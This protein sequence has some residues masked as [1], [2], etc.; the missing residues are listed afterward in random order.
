[1]ML[2]WLLIAGPRLVLG[3]ADMRCLAALVR[4]EQL[5]SDVAATERAVGEFCISSDLRSDQVSELIAPRAKS[6]AD[7]SLLAGMRGQLLA[8]ASKD[9]R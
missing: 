2:V 8:N 4:H 7:D 3:E 1:M 6:A 9:R 5:L